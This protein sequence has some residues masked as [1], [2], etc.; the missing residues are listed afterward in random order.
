M[1]H[2]PAHVHVSAIRANARNA[3]TLLRVCICA[4]PDADLGHVA[5]NAEV[6]HGSWP[7]A[8][9][10]AR[11]VGI[12]HAFRLAIR[13]A[14]NEFVIRDSAKES[15]SDK[16]LAAPSNHSLTAVGS[17]SAPKET[18]RMTRSQHRTGIWL[19]EFERDQ[20]RHELRRLAH[21]GSIQ[22]TQITPE[23]PR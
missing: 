11:P 20:L 21:V 18:P 19:A 10:S 17:C 9:T 12:A 7:H 22:T 2:I 1:M 6:T 4:A 14:T 15:N 23:L 16:H 5:G 8:R 13:E 3:H